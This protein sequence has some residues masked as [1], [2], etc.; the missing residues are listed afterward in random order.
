MHPDHV[1]E[2]VAVQVGALEEA[3]AQLDLRVCRLELRDRT[4]IYIRFI[5]TT[6][7]ALD[8]PGLG[9][10]RLGDTEVDEEFVLY[11]DCADFDSQ[12]P[13]VDLLDAEEEPLPSERWPRDERRHGIVRGHHIY[14]DRKFFCRPG[15]RQFHTHRQHE[16]QPWDAVREQMTVDGIAVGILRDFRERWT[17]R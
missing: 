13:L 14:G 2:L 4:N 5:S 6:K 17:I 11:L 9:A 15:T 8:V 1:A 7:R 3:V 12:P 16:D 10:V